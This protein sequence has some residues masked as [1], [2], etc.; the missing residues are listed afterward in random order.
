MAWQPVVHRWYFG[1][2]DGEEKEPRGAPSW[3]F[4]RSAREILKIRGNIRDRE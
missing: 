4:E 3:K 1:K 2:K